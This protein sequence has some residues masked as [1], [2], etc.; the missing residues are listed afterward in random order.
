MKN[1]PEQQDLVRQCYYD[2]P[3]EN[4]AERFSASDEW[5]AVKDLLHGYLPGKVLDLGAGRGISSYAFAKAGSEVIALEPDQSAV[6][7]A[8]AIRS[9]F[10]KSQLPISI[11]S[12]YGET[13]PFADN[14]F[15]IVYGRAV[16][17]HATDLTQF[18][19]ESARVL[20]TGGIFI[21]TREHVISQKEDLQQFLNSHSLHCLYGG[22]NAYRLEEYTQ[23][24]TAAGLK[25]SKILGPFSTA[26]NYAPM[27]RPEFNSMLTTIL[28]GRIGNRL[29]GRLA[30][31][32][33]TQMLMGKYLSQ[34]S[35]AAGRLYS[36]LAVKK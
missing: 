15:D 21:V 32:R 7:G 14:S 31:K 29:A 22:E 17:H 1:Q 12:E 4:A 20:R 16:L 25:M 8:E 24:I 3:L 35:E 18:C 34:K 5:C 33:A 23:A 10:D 28:A 6:V 11:V 13:L 26:I 9:L 27:T 30:S 2:D 19:R 36:L